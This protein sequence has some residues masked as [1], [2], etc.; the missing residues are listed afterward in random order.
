[1]VNFGWL[2]INGSLMVKGG[3]VVR[4]ID[5]ECAGW[6]LEYWEYTTCYHSS[7]LTK[8]CWCFWDMMKDEMD[9][10]ADE[11]EVDHCISS[12]FI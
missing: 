9:T 10:Y 12:F 3:K 11:L 1:M 2:A 5:W 7:L 4:I 6:Y 8:S